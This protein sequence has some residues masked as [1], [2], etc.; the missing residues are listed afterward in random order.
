MPLRI[1][2]L[3]S[4]RFSLAAACL[5]SP[6]AALAQETTI[7]NWLTATPP[8]GANS[9][10][11]PVAHDD[12]ITHFAH[13]IDRVKNK[14]V[15]L[16]FDGDS[17]TDFWEGRGKDVWKKNYA[18][19]NPAD[20]GIS[21]DRTEHLLWRLDHGQ[22]DGLHPKMVVLMIGTNNL[23]GNTEAQIAEGI[24]AIVHEYQKRLP[25][26]VLLLQGIFP[27]GEKPTDSNRQKIKTINA[28]I[29][30]LAD[31]NKVIYM[32]LSDKFLQPD[33]TLPRDMMPDTLHPSTKGYEVWAD[34]IRPEIEKVFGKTVQ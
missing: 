5:L 15:D 9:A 25:D 24:T 14:R 8:P 23:G 20:F 1:P 2:L 4:C 26:A 3:S 33:G 29:S 17:I 19:F 30:K 31:G 28:M 16:V 7:P 11:F 34:A 27:R 13:N 12:W 32:D 6:F 10:A 22:V 18:Q 21:G